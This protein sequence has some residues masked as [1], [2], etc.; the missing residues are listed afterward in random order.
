MAA[1]CAP[2]NSLRVKAG[3]MPGARLWCQ[4]TQKHDENKATIRCHKKPRDINRMGIPSNLDKDKEANICKKQISTRGRTAGN[5]PRQTRE[6]TKKK[7]PTQEK[8]KQTRETKTIQT[9]PHNLPR[10]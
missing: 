7:S 1:K 4:K 9:N 8:M 6:L 3:S 2:E 5:D 10:R